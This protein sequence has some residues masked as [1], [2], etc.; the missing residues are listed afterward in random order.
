MKLSN[1]GS[2]GHGFFFGTLEGEGMLRSPMTGLLSSKHQ[3]LQ[4]QKGKWEETQQKWLLSNHGK[5]KKRTKDSYLKFI[6]Q[7]IKKID[8]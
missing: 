3:T 7:T 6:F 2:M 1:L 8:S 4:P 5:K